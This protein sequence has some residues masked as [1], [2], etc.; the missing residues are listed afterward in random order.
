[1]IH[2]KQY[3]HNLRMVTICWDQLPVDFT[4]IAMVT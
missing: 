3:A 1:M 4:H 2:L